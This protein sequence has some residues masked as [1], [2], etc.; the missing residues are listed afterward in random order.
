MLCGM[1]KDKASGLD[2]FSMV[3]FQTCWEVVGQ[4]IMKV[5]HEFHSLAEFEKGFNTSFIALISKKSRVVE[6]TNFRITSP[7]NGVYKIISKVLAERMSVVMGS[8]ISRT[9]CI[10]EEGKKN[11]GL[12]VDCQRMH[13]LEKEAYLECYVS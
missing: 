11:H 12:G 9:Q 1:T 4:D 5:L 7:I 2:G 10:C 8:I 6:V 13:R 3:F